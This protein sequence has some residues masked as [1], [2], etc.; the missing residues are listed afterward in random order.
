MRDLS[1]DTGYFPS[2][3]FLEDGKTNNSLFAAKVPRLQRYELQITK[4][5]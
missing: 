3:S 4:N 1:I 5:R 2:L